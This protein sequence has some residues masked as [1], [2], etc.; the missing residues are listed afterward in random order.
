MAIANMAIPFTILLLFVNGMFLFTSYLPSNQA[1]TQTYG[2]QLGLNQG[3]MTKIQ[4]TFSDAN[5]DANHLISDTNGLG[6]ATN[7][8]NT[9]VTFLWS[10]FFGLGQAVVGTFN[11]V[12][13]IVKY[14]SIIFFG[15]AIWID[16]FFNASWGAGFAVLGL[17]FKGFFFII[18]LFGFAAI[19]LPILTGARQT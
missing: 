16:Y 5:V 1:N 17:L 12:V 2:T 19:L 4:S 14:L 13:G 3:D 15:Y 6:Q 8:A 9:G 18:Q 11:I 7:T 10:L